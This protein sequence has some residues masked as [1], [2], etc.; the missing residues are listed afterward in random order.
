MPALK[1][2]SNNDISICT[3]AEHSAILHPAPNWGCATACV[4]RPGGRW[5]QTSLPQEK[6][7]DYLDKIKKPTDWY[8]TPNEFRKSRSIAELSSLRACWVDID[9]T[10][11]LDEVKKRL[12]S[13]PPPSLINFSGRGFHV[14]WL[15]E[16]QMKYELSLWNMMQKKLME[17][18]GGDPN[19]IDAARVLRLVGTINSKTSEQCRMVGGDLHYYDFD[20]LAHEL[21]PDRQDKEAEVHTIA[22]ERINRKKPSTFH[23]RI[24]ALGQA[25]LWEGRFKD[26]R[27]L[28]LHRWENDIGKGNRDMWLFIASNAISWL[29]PPTV[30]RREVR[31][32]AEQ[33]CPAWNEKEVNARMQAVFKRA[34]MLEKGQTVEWAGKQIDPRYRFKTETIVEWLQ[35]TDEEMETLNLRHLINDDIRHA[36]DLERDKKRRRAKGI[37]ERN[38]YLSSCADAKRLKVA[39][40]KELSESGLSAVDIA[41]TTGFGISTVYRLL[42]G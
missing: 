16:S 38:A 32:L 29:T 28:A 27:S 31:A 2:I 33:V 42:R 41:Q 40:V 15:F 18:A 20:E 19:A 4:A 36:H 35:I 24:G 22:I 25:R 21:L 37:V 17:T 34:A 11:N 13:L 14:Y 9:D 7:T 26:L 30:L 23:R 8:I 6:M 10:S 12:D 5:R 3:P 39:R 1:A